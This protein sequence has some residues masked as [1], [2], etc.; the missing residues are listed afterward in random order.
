MKVAKI[1]AINAVFLLILI[2]AFS[3]LYFKA[4]FA[5]SNYRPSYLS[6]ATDT[7][8]QWMTEH[9]PWGAWHKPQGRGYKELR[10]FGVELIANSYGARDKERSKSSEASRVVVLGDSFVEGFGVEAAQ[11]FTDQLESQTGRPFLNFGSSGDFGPLQYSLVYEQLAAQFDHDQVLVAILPDNDFTDNDPNHW[12][13]VSEGAYLKRY[14]PY[15]RKTAES[16][17]FEHF[18]TVERPDYALSFADYRDHA[19]AGISVKDRIQRSTWFYGVYRE[20]RYYTR[21]SSLTAGTYSGYFD[22]TAEQLAATFFYLKKIKA[23][24]QG[25]P[26][27]FFT[28]PRLADLQRLRTDNSPLVTEMTNFAAENGFSY[29]DLAAGMLASTEQ[30]TDLFLPCDGHWSAYGHAEAM[31]ILKIEVFK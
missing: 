26:V 25:R 16:E 4:G 10:C 8:Q 19:K 11:R 14:R 1:I 27:A 2:E 7:E 28:I 3:F 13:A 12:Q 30:V 21:G 24:A 20:L 5:I 31:R 18:Y 15:W 29:V 9:N 17:G 22:Y 23:A 6:G